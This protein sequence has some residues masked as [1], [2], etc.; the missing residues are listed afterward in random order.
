MVRLGI[1][2]VSA[3]NPNPTNMRPSYRRDRPPPQPCGGGSWPRVRPHAAHYLSPLS[4]PLT[5]FSEP[6][7]PLSPTSTTLCAIS[8]D[9]FVRHQAI[10]CL[11]NSFARSKPTTGVLFRQ[12]TKTSRRHA[13]ITLGVKE[14]QPVVQET[15]TQ[16]EQ[17]PRAASPPGPAFSRVQCILDG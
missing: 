7:N 10:G 4:R 9:R 13:K 8:I 1:P 17:N 6:P 2:G 15:T 5:C 16:K 11:P 3:I 14:K 12:P